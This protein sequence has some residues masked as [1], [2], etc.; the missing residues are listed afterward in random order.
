MAGLN[1]PFDYGTN[2]IGEEIIFRGLSQQQRFAQNNEHGATWSAQDGIEKSQAYFQANVLKTDFSIPPQ[3]QH[4]K[5]EPPCPWDKEG[6]DLTPADL[7][8]VIMA[9]DGVYTYSYRVAQRTDTQN[10]FDIG[11]TIADYSQDQSK[12]DP[13]IQSEFAYYGHSGVGTYTGPAVIVIEKLHRGTVQ[14][15][16]YYLFN[17]K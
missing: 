3:Y 7:M 16:V 13:K 9:N 1:T 17:M 12:L 15:T 14:E 2:L 8:P 10:G 4:C 5:P 11:P 6:D